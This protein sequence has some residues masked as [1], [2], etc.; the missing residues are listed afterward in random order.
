MLLLLL[1]SSFE[2]AG[3]QALPPL[4]PGCAGGVVCSGLACACSSLLLAHP[5][6]GRLAPARPLQWS[7]LCGGL[8]LPPPG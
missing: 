5:G 7:L 6:Y 2:A 1:A 8:C 4:H 3:L